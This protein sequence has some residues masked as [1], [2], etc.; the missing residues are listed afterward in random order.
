MLDKLYEHGGALVYSVIKCHFITKPEFFQKS[1]NVFAGLDVAVIEG[2]RVLGS[3]FGSD[4]R[5]NS[6]LN[7]NSLNYYKIVDKLARHSNVSSQLVYKS[8]TNGLQQK[9][10]F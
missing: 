9:L 6:F 5:C 3:V 10:T 8:F 2:H 1:N 4:K 7:E